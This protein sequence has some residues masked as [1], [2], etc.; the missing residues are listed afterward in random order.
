MASNEVEDGEVDDAKA[1]TTHSMQS[2]KQSVLSAISSNSASTPATSS[3]Q[4]VFAPNTIEPAVR[5]GTPKVAANTISQS[6]PSSRSEVV[7]NSSAVSVPHPGLPSRP[8]V[9]F[10][11]HI[12]PDRH[13]LSRQGDRRDVYQSR[14]DRSSDGI[15]DRAREPLNFE[16]RPPELLPRDMGRLGDRSL[17]AERDRDR[18]D[19]KRRGMD[20]HRDIRDG[21]DS[22]DHRDRLPLD[23]S[24]SHDLDGRLSRNDDMQPPRSV[25]AESNAGAA[26]NPD[27]VINPARAAQIFGT[28]EA[29]RLEPARATR[30][31]HR[32]RPSSRPHSPRRDRFHGPDR[33]H[34]DARRN[35]RPPNGR[36]PPYGQ[37]YNRGRHD[38]T[39]PS[40]VGPR[41]DWIGDRG[42]FERSRDAS[43]FQPTPPLVRSLDPDHG[44]LNQSSRSQA[45]PNFGRLNP[46]P[47]SQIPS[48][49]SRDRGNRNPGSGNRMS[50][51][52]QPRFDP[53]PSTQE[54]ARPP[55]PDKQPPTGPAASRVPR[56][57]ASGIVEPPTSAPLSTPATPA[58]SSPTAGV[59][60]ERLRHIDT[61]ATQ[62]AGPN[63][64]AQIPQQPAVTPSATIPTGVHPSRLH[65]F[66]DEHLQ[67]RQGPPPIQTSSINSSAPRPTSP[68]TAGPPSGPKS[69]Q[70]TSTSAMSPNGVVPPTGPSSANDRNQRTNIRQFQNLQNTINQAGHRG[71]SERTERGTNIRGRSSRNSLAGPMS[72]LPPSPVPLTPVSLPANRDGAGNGPSDR[73]RDLINSDRTVDLFPSRAPNGGDNERDRERDRERERADSRSGTGGRREGARSGRHSRRTSRS[74]SG[75]RDPERE[76]ERDRARERGAG[77]TDDGGRG[78]YRDRGG[79]GGAGNGDGRELRHGERDLRRRDGEKRGDGRDLLPLARNE[80][81]WAGGAAGAGPGAG[82]GGGGGGPGPGG[83]RRDMRSSGDARRDTRSDGSGR[84]RRGE[85]GGMGPDIRGHDKRPRR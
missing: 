57:T 38:D 15:R 13:L 69:L 3:T 22:R 28:A 80:P 66:Q 6:A 83:P 68:L 7:R 26:T 42:S 23:N 27:P 17:A 63:T 4:D 5:E 51:A 1:L 14:A 39:Q 37:E 53:R 54:V 36:P 56:R 60:P 48:G 81:E 74:R 64:T 45:D 65:G 24:R 75:V 12:P 34:P 44:R 84:K 21:R 11:S 10:P 72:D 71:A 76:R 85:E 49:P 73:S 40:V 19:S 35:D 59:H 47:T 55:T 29:P 18:H 78:E 9:P 62:Q 31:E 79:R 33:E 43:A 32:D 16:R 70:T 20:P 41:D 2:P 50:N 25:T 46:A 77:P 67:A 61:T 58:A 82:G 8:D 52:P 30:D